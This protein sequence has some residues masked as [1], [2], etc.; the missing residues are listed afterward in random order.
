MARSRSL[1]TTSCLAGTSS[2]CKNRPS[3]SNSG[4]EHHADLD[5]LHCRTKKFL[6]KMQ[7][8][9][10]LRVVSTSKGVYELKF[11]NVVNDEA[12]DDDE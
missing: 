5:H 7:L 4:E 9:D 6:K 2:T 11:F 12:D 8:R 3:R 1:P 10:W